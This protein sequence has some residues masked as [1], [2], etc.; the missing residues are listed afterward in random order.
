[1]TSRIR[2]L[3]TAFAFQPP[4]QDETGVVDDPTLTVLLEPRDRRVEALRHHKDWFEGTSADESIGQIAD[5]ESASGRLD[6]VLSW[7]DEST[8]EYYRRLGIAMRATQRF[9][10]DDS[11]P[12]SVAGYLRHL[13][14]T[15]WQPGVSFS[16][17]LSDAIRVL[18]KE[19][20]EAAE[21]F[22][23]IAGI[24]CAFPVL[25]EDLSSL[26]AED[27]AD[28][29][30]RISALGHSPLL[31]VAE[32][33]LLLSQTA[34]SPTLADR[35]AQIVAELV[36]PEGQR[37]AQLFES[38]LRY[39]EHLW[40]GDPKYRALAVHIRLALVWAHT[41]RLFAPAGRR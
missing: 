36:S 5:T 4:N 35:A 9:T 33:R 11:R 16:A 6:E 41:H 8:A 12:P 10:A 27:L 38:L 3:T 23:R 29:I 40:I 1:M 13:R 25:E 15:E 39:S 17:A 18:L 21:V 22:A 37:D 24:P 28:T 26:S 32:L 30:T 2:P 7:R 34:R 20:T 31:R 19:G 14:L